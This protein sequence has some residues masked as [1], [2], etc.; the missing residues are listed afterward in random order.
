MLTDLVI[1]EVSLVDRPAN[2]GAEVLVF[3]RL[4][5]DA[6]A[7]NSYSVKELTKAMASIDYAKTGTTPEELWEDYVAE[8]MQV[9][10][11]E[12]VARQKHPPDKLTDEEVKELR[13]KKPWTLA[14]ATQAAR[15]TNIGQGLWQ[16][17]QNCVRER[18][19]AL[20]EKLDIKNENSVSTLPQFCR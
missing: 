20:L 13:Q 1:E 12:L 19:T 10:N 8:V 2:P 4:D 7:L 6:S 16:L 5:L 18:E 14:Q 3:K 17:V 9:H 15:K 11:T